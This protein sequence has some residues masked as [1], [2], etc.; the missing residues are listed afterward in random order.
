LFIALLEGNSVGSVE[1]VGIKGLG[2]V[3]AERLLGK[4]IA[5]FK[6]K[7]VADVSADLP[8]PLP[9]TLG[10]LGGVLCGVVG[11]VLLGV[12]GLAM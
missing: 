4:G 8:L 5:L 10:V 9:L 7:G 12:L 1:S 11:G 3:G 2:R 6:L